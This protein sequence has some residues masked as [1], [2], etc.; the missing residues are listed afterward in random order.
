MKTKDSG[1]YINNPVADSARPDSIQ[2]LE[3]LGVH[4]NAVEK[5]PD[6]VATGIMQVAELLK[7]RK[8]TGKPTLM[9]SKN[10]SWIAD[11]FERYRWMENKSADNTMKETPLK[12]NDDAMDAIRYYAMTRQKK[13]ISGTIADESI[14]LASI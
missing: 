9:F 8:D 1:K 5:N 3:N 10:L 11:E 2:E 14:P 12:V 13:T 7:I 4:F 6:S